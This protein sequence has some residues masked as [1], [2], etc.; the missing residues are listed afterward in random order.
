MALNG[1]LLMLAGGLSYTLGLIFYA[2]E[3]RVRYFH[4]VWHV[5]VMAGSLLHFLVVYIYVAGV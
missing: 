1:F 4:A 5:F 2:M 3:E